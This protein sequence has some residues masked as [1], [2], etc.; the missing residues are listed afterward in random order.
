MLP[1]SPIRCVS[2]RSWLIFTTRLARHPLGYTSS[3]GQLGT[4][5]IDPR[6]LVDVG[7]ATRVTKTDVGGVGKWSVSFAAPLTTEKFLVD[8]PT[9]Y[10]AFKQSTMALVPLAEQFVGRDIDGAMCTLSG[11]LGVGH[12]AGSSAV[13]GW[14]ADPATRAKFRGT[15]DT[16]KLTNGIF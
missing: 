3:R 4:F 14:V 15:T 8:L 16:F 12:A 2:V 13:A 7:L 11:L 6:R 5:G 1:K 10:E 9:Q